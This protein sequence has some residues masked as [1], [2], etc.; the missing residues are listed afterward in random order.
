LVVPVTLTNTIDTILID[1]EDETM[2]FFTVQNQ[3]AKSNIDQ[4]FKTLQKLIRTY[5][6]NLNFTLN[7]E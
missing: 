1:F 2:T 4:I 6:K 3:Y 7:I 5:R